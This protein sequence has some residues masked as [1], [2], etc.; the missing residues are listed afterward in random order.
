MIVIFITYITT[1]KISY[2]DTHKNNLESLSRCGSPIIKCNDNLPS[3]NGSEKVKKFF[4][5][6]YNFGTFNNYFVPHKHDKNTCN[7]NCS[8]KLPLVKLLAQKSFYFYGI[9]LYNKLPIGI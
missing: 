7:N 9:K 4:L 5:K 3:V 1:H 8:T 2:T 6:D